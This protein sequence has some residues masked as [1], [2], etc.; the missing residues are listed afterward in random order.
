[1]KKALFAA[2]F[3]AFASIAVAP[4]YVLAQSQPATAANAPKIAV[5]ACSTFKTEGIK[6]I[7]NCVGGLFGSAVNFLMAASVVVIVWGAFQ[8]IYSEEKRA[9][10]RQT[11]IWGIIGLFVMISIWGFVNILNNTFKLKTNASDVLNDVK[12][13]PF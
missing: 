13:V 8:M 4:V 1:M 9:S 3:V 11:V 2:L 5:D 12:I 10:G 6:G 7:A